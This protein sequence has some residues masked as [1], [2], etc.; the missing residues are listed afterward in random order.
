MRRSVRAAAWTAAALSLCT[1]GALAGPS[2]AYE[3]DPAPAVSY[4]EHAGSRLTAANLGLNDLD[5]PARRAETPLRRRSPPTP[6]L[7]PSPQSILDE[8]PAPRRAARSP[9]WS[10][11]IPA[12]TTPD[13]ETEC[14]ARAVYWE[15]KGEPL[16]GQLAV[17]EVII[18][19]ADRAASRRPS[20]ASSA[21]A[22]NSRSSAAA[23]FRSRRRLARLAHRGRDRPDRACRTSPTAPRRAR[24]L[25]RPP[26]QSGLA[27]D[28]RRDGRE[29][30]LLPL[31]RAAG[32]RPLL[33]SRFILVCAAMAS[34]ARFADRLLR[35]RAAGRAGRRARRH[36]PVLPRRHVRYLR[37]AA[38]QRPPRRHGRDRR[39]GAARSSSRS[40]SRAPTCSA[41][42]NGAT[43]SIIA[44]CSTGRCRPASASSRSTARRS[45][46]IARG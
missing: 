19:R 40:R 8:E 5:D 11:T 36:A 18:N 16:T 7:P 39:P 10:A 33:R 15:S 45:A 26:G 24:F 37:G 3:A 42:A 30:R 43:I 22:A 14:L 38:A 28:P 20:A 17:A 29:S 23:I 12:A 13:A 31:G 21:S 44:T 1:A 4:T 34:L 25:P 2:I 32:A 35:R 46:P 41:T 9:T 27:A 6:S